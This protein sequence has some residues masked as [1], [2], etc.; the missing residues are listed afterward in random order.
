M[1]YDLSIQH[2]L[3]SQSPTV[4]ITNINVTDES[5]YLTKI[6]ITYDKCMNHREHEDIGDEPLHSILNEIG[7]WP[8]AKGDNWYKSNF[9]LDVVLSKLKELGY[10]HDFFAKI[11]VAPHVL[12]HKFNLIYIGASDLGLDDKS[13]YLD[14][15]YTSTMD[16]YLKFMLKAAKELGSPFSAAQIQQ[17]MEQVLHFEK[18]IA[19]VCLH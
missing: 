14:K 4:L 13:Y 2:L 9:S 18:K 10:E 8:V 6:R 17:E 19:K 1:S 3:N 5:H 11:D 7:G 15:L 16:A 12:A